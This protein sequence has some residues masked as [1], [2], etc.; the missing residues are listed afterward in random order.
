MQRK[1]RSGGY[2]SNDGGEDEGQGEGKMPMEVTV[3]LWLWSRGGGSSDSSSGVIVSCVVSVLL[4][5]V[6]LMNW[7]KWRKWHR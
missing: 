2:G 5:A 7:Y 4:E 1:L 3:K 6:Q